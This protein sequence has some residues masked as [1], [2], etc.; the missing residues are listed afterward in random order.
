MVEVI[1]AGPVGI[2]LFVVAGVADGEQEL[3]AL[4]QKLS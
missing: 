4:L 1:L 3:R 2:H